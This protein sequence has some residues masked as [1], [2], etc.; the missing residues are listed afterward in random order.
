[1]LAGWSYYKPISLHVP[2]ELLTDSSMFIVFTNDADIGAHG[3]AN[4]Y[5]MRFTL[6]DDT[7]L[8]GQRIAHSV[9]GGLA[10]GL[11][12]IKVPSRSAIIETPIRAY[13]DN[14]GAADGMDP[15]N[16]YDAATKGAWLFNSSGAL[17]C[18]DS[19]ANHNDGTNNGAA[20]AV[21]PLTGLG[22]AL[23]E[24]GDYIDVGVLNPD[25]NLSISAWINQPLQNAALRLVAYKV[26]GY[27]YLGC[28]PWGYMTG[29]VYPWEV[30]GAASVWGASWHHIA[31]TWTS[32]GTLQNYV[33][34]SP[35][36]SIGT[37]GSITPAPTAHVTIGGYS[38]G[39]SL[40]GSIADIKIEY[41]QR[42]AAWMSAEY[43]NI[44]DADH[45]QTW[46]AEVAA[47]PTIRWPWQQ[48]YRRRMSI[49]A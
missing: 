33:D 40:I 30:N 10:T 19:T 24:A 27:W 37:T 1:M 41:A 35:D 13:Y 36:G 7:L 17:D 16:V 18:L 8:S 9:A 28:A 38:G 5:D 21:G 39:L 2:D 3:L 34:G 45:M 23:F 49:G 11:Y 46:G 48:R 42:T 14:P 26:G 32:A 22:A 25:T 15:E 20:S 6:D 29:Y 47:M 4:G 43:H 44:V 12:R 31:F